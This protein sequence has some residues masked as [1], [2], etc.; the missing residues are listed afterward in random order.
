MK[1]RGSEWQL[2]F[3]TTL[4]QM[5]VGA[6]S[7]WG[8]AALFLPTP[9]PLLEGLYPAVLLVIVLVSLAL[10]T[11]SAGLH[12]GRPSR[13]VFSISNWR[14]SWLSREA[15]LGAG[16][17]LV[18][19]ALFIRNRLSMPFGTPDRFLI[20]IGVILGLLLVYG[21]SRLYMLRT[22][23]I[24]NNAGTPAAFIMT[25]FLLGIVS[26]LSIWIGLRLENFSNFITIATLLALLFVAMQWAS[27]VFVILF[28]SNRFGVAAE[29]ARW[30]WSDL[31][32]ILV[33][34]FVAGLFG[35]GILTL[36]FV[37]NL[38]IYL[39][40]LAFGLILVSEILGRFVF[41]GY[42]RREGI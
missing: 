5:A 2:V 37:V 40:F 21:I 3:F 19:L 41:Y 14:S 8:V 12:L 4:M 13:V 26:V 22:V 10:G 24:W 29:S 42:F 16:F 32:L 27:F 36:H 20:F 23:P 7:L 6:F 28:A 38:P 30:M 33:L 34:R 11:L 15:M 9:N 35:A 18:G 25:A 39:F 17:G 31:R 1:N